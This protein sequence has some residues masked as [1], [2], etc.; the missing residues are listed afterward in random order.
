M[1]ERRNEMA[2]R[3]TTLGVEV[4]QDIEASPTPWWCE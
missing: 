4:D 3:D 1:R 2:K